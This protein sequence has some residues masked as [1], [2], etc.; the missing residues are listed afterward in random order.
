MYVHRDTIEKKSDQLLS[1]RMANIKRACYYYCYYHYE[2]IYSISVELLQSSG[3]PNY[4][5]IIII[6]ITR[7]DCTNFLRVKLFLLLICARPRC[8]NGINRIYTIRMS[9]KLP[10]KHTRRYYLCK[11]L[12]SIY[13]SILYVNYYRA[14]E[15]SQ[16]TRT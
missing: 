6:I 8:D 9:H 5:I 14:L 15:R 4:N 10:H 16:C 7:R 3:H 11:L 2:R 12:Q 13:A 1:K